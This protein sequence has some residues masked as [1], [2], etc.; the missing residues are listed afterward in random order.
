MR[1]ASGARS[2][3]PPPLTLPTFH[4]TPALMSAALMTKPMRA[5]PARRVASRRSVAPRA[6]SDVNVVIGGGK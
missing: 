5:A 4:R 6:L 3:T 1:R 2:R